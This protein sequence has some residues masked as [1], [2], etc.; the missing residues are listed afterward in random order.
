V[1]F[2]EG[3]FLGLQTVILQKNWFPTGAREV[4]L[5]RDG[6]RPQTLRVDW[7][8]VRRDGVF[9]APHRPPVVLEP[10]SVLRHTLTHRPLL[11]AG[12]AS[13]PALLTL[14]A[15]ALLTAR[16]HLRKAELVLQRDGDDPYLGH[17]VD[18]RWR[19]TARLG[20]GGFGS[21]Y[22]ADDPQD[23]PVAV[24]L[25]SRELAEEPEFRQ[26]FLREGRIASRLV[27]PNIVLAHQYGDD[28]GQP[29]LVMDLVAGGSL[30]DELSRGPLSS[31]RI[32]EIARQVGAGLQFAHDRGVVHR[33]LKPDNLLIDGHR[34]KIA[35][36]G[37]AVAAEFA[38]LRLTATGAVL[39]TKA[40]LSPDQL[41][42]QFS[43]LSDQYTLGII[44]YELLTGRVPQHDPS[45]DTSDVQAELQRL[46]SPPSP[47]GISPQVD[48][49]VLRML[50]VDPAERYPSVGEAVREFCAMLER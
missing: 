49:V 20:G 1:R 9:P 36:F 16:R 31:P 40:Y 8:Q 47:P 19:L 15:L 24:K 27:H 25:L 48:R 42:G 38:A 18:G 43:P 7:D 5:S 14:A 46:F 10:R 3:K 32:A 21:V 35:D 50:A 13:L 11:V 44:L 34:V 6:Y 37:M 33:D 45:A 39:G 30:A 2:V 12:L 41:R 26:R 28:Q 22:R 23:R 17:V 29:Y 4:V